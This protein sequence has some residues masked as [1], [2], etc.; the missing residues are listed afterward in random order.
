MVAERD[1]IQHEL[2]QKKNE[3]KDLAEKI[4]ELE[5]LDEESKKL[6]D[7]ELTR[8]RTELDNLAKSFQESQ[9]INQQVYDIL[10]RYSQQKEPLLRSQEVVQKIN[11][12]TAERESRPNIS[13]AQWNNDYSKR[14][15]RQELITLQKELDKEKGWWDKWIEDKRNKIDSNF[16]SKEELPTFIV[17]RLDSV[18]KRSFEIELDYLYSSNVYLTYSGEIEKGKEIIKAISEYYKQK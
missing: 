6:R 3:I 7:Q 17:N 11:T 14:P 12:L 2:T 8:L 10:G 18:A 16:Y 4:K 5:S 9:V 15:T 13:L 1:N